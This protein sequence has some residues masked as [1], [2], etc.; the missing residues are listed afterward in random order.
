MLSR[1]LKILTVHV[2]DWIVHYILLVLGGD[3]TLRKQNVTDRQKK[4]K[5]GEISESLQTLIGTLSKKKGD[6]I[7]RALTDVSNVDSENTV[8]AGI[9]YT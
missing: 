4:S 5:I 9:L 1:R 2:F 3:A 6:K 7:K 8:L